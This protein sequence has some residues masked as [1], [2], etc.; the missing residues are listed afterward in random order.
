MNRFKYKKE[1]DLATVYSKSPI[2]AYNFQDISNLD[3]SERRRPK[4]IDAGQKIGICDESEIY[5]IIVAKADIKLY[6]DPDSRAGGFTTDSALWIEL[7]DKT[8]YGL[9]ETIDVADSDFDMDD[10]IDDIDSIEDDYKKLNLDELLFE[11]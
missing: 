7:D 9:G 3:V 5:H 6:S 10:M 8:V 11:A 4:T 2:K 1:F